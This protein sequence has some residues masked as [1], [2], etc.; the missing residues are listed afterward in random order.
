MVATPVEQRSSQGAERGP[1]GTAVSRQQVSQCLPGLSPGV[2]PN[3]LRPQDQSVPETPLLPVFIYEKQTV[4]Q[5][6]VS[7]EGGILS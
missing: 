1:S 2:E 5:A 4:A 7:L 3:Q 6:V